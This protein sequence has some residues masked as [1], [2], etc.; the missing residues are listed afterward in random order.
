[1]NRRI[2]MKFY[3]GITSEDRYKLEKLFQPIDIDF[4]KRKEDL[5]TFNGVEYQIYYRH[6]G[7][8]NDQIKNFL[9]SNFSSKVEKL[10]VLDD[11]AHILN[12]NIEIDDNKSWGHSHAGFTLKDGNT[13]TFWFSS[14]SRLKLQ[15]IVEILDEDLLKIPKSFW[16]GTLQNIN[17]KDSD[18]KL[19]MDLMV[20]DRADIFRIIGKK[21]EVQLTT[22]ELKTIVGLT[23]FTRVTSS[24]LIGRGETADIVN[25]R[26]VILHQDNCNDEIV[27]EIINGF[28]SSNDRDSFM[29]SLNKK[30]VIEKFKDSPIVQLL[31]KLG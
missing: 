13:Y 11:L 6:D 2:K 29:K 24:G 3:S 22:D 5:K 16:R 15:D 18:R 23:H 4:K 9:N 26:A 21:S 27:L 10:K 17:L 25:R 14:S 1:M 8:T 19:I 20:N 31:T 7:F 12:Y 28:N 30:S